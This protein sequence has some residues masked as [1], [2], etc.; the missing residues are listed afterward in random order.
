MTFGTQIRTAQRG[1]DAEPSQI[2][3]VGYAAATN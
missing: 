3:G 1:L 2:G